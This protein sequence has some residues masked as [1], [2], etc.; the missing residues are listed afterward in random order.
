M[1]R[2]QFFL[3]YCR[4]YV[5]AIFIEFFFAGLG[6]FRATDDYAW[7]NVLGLVLLGGAVL[8]FL[9]AL[10]WR[11]PGSLARM[12]FQLGLLNGAMLFTG[13]IN[14]DAPA[15]ADFERG[16]GA[17]HAVLAVGTY[18]LSSVIVK[19]TAAAFGL[20]R[21]LTLYYATSRLLKRET[22]AA[23]NGEASRRP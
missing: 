8:M 7:H 3:Q 19:R 22:A 2:E 4:V 1:K 17:F 18:V 11:F 10:V 12:S 6:A 20:K 23:H 16:F 5:W 15:D 21:P 9:L 14:E 13:I